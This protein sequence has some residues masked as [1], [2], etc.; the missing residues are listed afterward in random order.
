MLVLMTI[1]DIMKLDILRPSVLG[2]EF[3]GYK[4]GDASQL[5]IEKPSWIFSKQNLAKKFDLSVELNYCL[6][7]TFQSSQFSG[8]WLVIMTLRSAMSWS[9]ALK[10]FPPSPGYCQNSRIGGFREI[11]ETPELTEP[12]SLVKSFPWKNLTAPF[13]L[14]CVFFL[15]K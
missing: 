7:S 8:R 10:H 9:D 6:T 11:G 3:C 12:K 15:M 14:V 4:P 2:A 13:T 1:H 5:Q